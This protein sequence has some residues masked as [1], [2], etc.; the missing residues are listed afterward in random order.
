MH[1]IS[2]VQGLHKPAEGNEV[3]EFRVIAAKVIPPMLQALCWNSIK[4]SMLRKLFFFLHSKRR[5]TR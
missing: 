3:D 1:L 4:E 5:K 2:W